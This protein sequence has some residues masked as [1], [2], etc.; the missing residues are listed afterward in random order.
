MLL[1]IVI[2]LPI[3]LM[4]IVKLDKIPRAYDHAISY[5]PEP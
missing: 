3:V 1:G 4:Q 5:Q 2:D